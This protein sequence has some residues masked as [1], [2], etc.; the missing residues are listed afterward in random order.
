[1]SHIRVE[2]RANNQ[3][4]LI[5]FGISRPECTNLEAVL[6]GVRVGFECVSVS[7]FEAFGDDGLEEAQG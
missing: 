7:M 6:A 1:V 5:A 4:L 3:D 2:L